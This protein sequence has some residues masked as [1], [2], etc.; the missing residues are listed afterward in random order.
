M[1]D[2]RSERKIRHS[3]ESEKGE[4]RVLHTISPVYDENSRILILGS[5]PSVKSREAGFF[6]GHPQNRFWRV[7]AALYREDVPRTTEEKRAFLLSHGIALYDVI[8]S[9][10]IRGSADASISAVVPSDLSGI[11]AAGR[12]EAIYVNGKTAENYY[13]KYQEKITGKAAIPL[14]ST[15]PANAAYSLEKLILAWK[16]IL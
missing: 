16:I 15:S 3:K 1:R 4:G 6:Y 5:F 13:R 8:E 2:G 7:L 14:P 11:L 10:E 12:I 9:C